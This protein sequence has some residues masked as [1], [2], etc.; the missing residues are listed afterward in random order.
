LPAVLQTIGNEMNQP[1][2]DE[3]ETAELLDLAK[4]L[5]IFLTVATVTPAKKTQLVRSA[6][7]DFTSFGFELF[8]LL[9]F[10]SLNY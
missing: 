4:L 1:K 3:E 5:A 9:V 8:K 7:L 2:P 6:W 10:N